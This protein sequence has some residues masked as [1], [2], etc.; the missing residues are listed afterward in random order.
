MKQL[1]DDLREFAIEVY[2]LGYSLGGG[3][4]EREC[5]DLSE[6][7]FAAVNLAEARMA[8]AKFALRAHMRC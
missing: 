7:M 8:G 3:V 2:Q 1:C 4:A 5:L 6:R